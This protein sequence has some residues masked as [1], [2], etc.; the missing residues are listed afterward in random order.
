MRG[1]GVTV[2]TGLTLEAKGV[3]KNGNNEGQGGKS[4]GRTAGTPHGTPGVHVQRPGRR[5]DQPSL[6]LS[7]Y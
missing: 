7:T 6:Q 4:S 2:D 1:A 5:R 3:G